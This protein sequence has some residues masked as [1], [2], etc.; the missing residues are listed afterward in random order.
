MAVDRIEV[1]VRSCAIVGS[2]G[3]RLDVRE[4]P[5]ERADTL[6][7]TMTTTPEYSDE[8]RMRQQSEGLSRQAEGGLPQDREDALEREIAEHDRADREL[9]HLDPEDNEARAPGQVCGRCGAVI[10]A[11]QDVRLRVD[12][13]WVHEVCPPVLGSA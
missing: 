8:E 12:G 10:T 3:V 7:A 9:T 11:D 13:R 1:S 2:G 6:E 5:C 4:T